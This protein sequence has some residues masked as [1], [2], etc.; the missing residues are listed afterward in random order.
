MEH[1]TIVNVNVG[2][3]EGNIGLTISFDDGE[4]EHFLFDL[5]VAEQIVKYLTKACRELRYLKNQ[6]GDGVAVKDE[7]QVRINP[8]G[9]R[10]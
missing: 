6:M 1:R 9:E 10:P 3:Y 8:P 2:M 4:R 5:P 7:G